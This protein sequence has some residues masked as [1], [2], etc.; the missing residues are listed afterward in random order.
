MPVFLAVGPSMVHSSSASDT[1]AV[2]DLLPTSQPVA[3]T[4]SLSGSA[5]PSTLVLS[6]E[7]LDQLFASL[8]PG[9]FPDLFG[10]DPSWDWRW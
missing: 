9:S 2:D 4:A 5:E 10:L 7:T 1:N 8:N 3:M 6:S